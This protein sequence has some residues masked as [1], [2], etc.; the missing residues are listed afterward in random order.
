MGRVAGAAVLA[1]LL[2]AAAPPCRPSVEAEKRLK[3]AYP[4]LDVLHTLKPCELAGDF[5]GDG[6]EDIALQVR[7][8]VTGK[9]GVAIEH[10][11]THEWFIAGAGN[12][13]SSAEDNFDW[14]DA[15]RVEKNRITH[16]GDAILAEKSESAS[17]LI[18]WSGHEYRWMQQGD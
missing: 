7:D 16:K 18:Y 12:R 17:G 14:M 4:L 9:V 10:S 6:V 3:H 1:F 15:W 2:I 8:H 11:K 13:M 5:D